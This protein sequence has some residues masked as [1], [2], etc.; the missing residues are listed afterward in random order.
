M[1]RI[2]RPAPAMPAPAGPPS[3]ARTA[4]QAW[5]DE[6]YTPAVKKRAERKDKFTTLSEVPIEPLY[7]AD[8]L[9]NFDPERDLDRKSVV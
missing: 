6:Q 7:T 4:K 1:S 8:D 9:A 5:L 2:V 3:K